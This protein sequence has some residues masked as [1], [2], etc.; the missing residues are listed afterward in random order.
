MQHIQTEGKILKHYMNNFKMIFSLMTNMHK[1]PK[2]DVVIKTT[3][4]Y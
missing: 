4:F 3:G 1:V 2:K